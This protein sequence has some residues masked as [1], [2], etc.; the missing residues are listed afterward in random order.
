MAGGLPIG[1]P[2][3]GGGTSYPGSGSPPGPSVFG[4]PLSVACADLV[5]LTAGT[6]LE[7]CIA[8]CLAA[9]WLG[10]LCSVGCTAICGALGIGGLVAC[11]ALSSGQIG[12]IYQPP[13]VDPPTPI[14]VPHPFA[15][16]PCTACG[17]AP[18][19]DLAPDEVVY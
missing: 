9:D 2:P 10:G 13:G 11:N 16:H 7:S 12:P 14:G 1:F 17:Q 15:G 6:C 4:I 8:P 5:G 3:S 18:I 19:D